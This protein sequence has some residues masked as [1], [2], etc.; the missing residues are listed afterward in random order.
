M[1]ARSFAREL[2]N[3]SA[4]H[5]FAEELEAFEEND[6]V[7]ANMI[8]DFFEWGAEGARPQQLA[9]LV[10]TETAMFVTTALQKSTGEPLFKARELLPG[11]WI[12]LH[13]KGT[14]DFLNKQRMWL[15][16]PEFAAAPSTLSLEGGEAAEERPS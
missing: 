14:F 11:W 7:I 2:T 8:S 5:P 6:A 13:P 15:Y 10:W 3:M 16:A 1:A 12:V 9:E 4:N